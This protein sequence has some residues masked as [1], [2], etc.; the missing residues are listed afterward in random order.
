MDGATVQL[1]T[2]MFNGREQVIPRGIKDHAKHTAPLVLETDGDAVGWIAMRKISRPI[3][4]IDDPQIRRL[5][6]FNA[7]LFF[8]QEPMGWK[9][10]PNTLDD[11]LLGSTIGVS[12]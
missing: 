8:G 11:T 6:L 9:M 3:Q 2:P 10:S 4:R 5:C 1:R 12:D 7:T